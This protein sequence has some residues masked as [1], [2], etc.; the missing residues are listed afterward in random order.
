M[1]DLLTELRSR[2]ITLWRDGDNL[3]F[4]APTGALTPE[5]RAEMGA[6]KSELLE[7]LLHESEAE[8]A[9][10]H[11]DRSAGSPLSF[12][13]EPLWILDQ[14]APGLATYNIELCWRIS[15]SLDVAA[16]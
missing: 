3:R 13:Q 9:I 14:I 15:G 8:D 16:L 6:R 10:P 11:T 4:S 1:N 2:D 5:L 7:T 12:S